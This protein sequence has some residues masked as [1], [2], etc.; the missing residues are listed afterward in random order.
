[1]MHDMSISTMMMIGLMALSYLFI[2]VKPGEWSTRMLFKGWDK[3]RKKTLQQK[4]VNDLYDAFELDKIKSGS[5]IKI[6]T[7]GNL[8]IIMYRKEDE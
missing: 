5:D 7:K 6:T 8:V 4:A 3:K 2:M 1:M